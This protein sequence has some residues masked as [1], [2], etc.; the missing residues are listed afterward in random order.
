MKSIPKQVFST[1]STHQWKLESIRQER[2]KLI[3]L[4]PDWKF[5]QFNDEACTQYIAHHFSGEVSSAYKRINPRYGAARADL[6][7]YCI[8]Y[9]EGGVYLDIKSTAAKPLT[10][11]VG[12]QGLYPLSQW[13]NRPGQPHHLWGVHKE[14]EHVPGGE[15]QQWFIA[16]PPKSKILGQVIDCVS[17]NISNYA[18]KMEKT[19]GKQ[20]VLTTT[21]PIAYTLAIAQ[22]IQKGDIKLGVDFEY[23]NAKHKGL[24]YSIFEN[25]KTKSSKTLKEDLAQYGCSHYSL[26]NEPVII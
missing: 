24:V 13:D 8:L 18:A 4:N 1:A 20:G 11:I 3:N 9:Q 15:F 22:L 14:L 17:E 19:A 7:R 21:G 25:D 23:I 2:E 12:D 6:F 16:S 10:E 26:H 5:H